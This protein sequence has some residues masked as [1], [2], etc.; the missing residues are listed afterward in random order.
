MLL[1]C[2]ILATHLPIRAS[3]RSEGIP[4]LSQKS[5]LLDCL[6]VMAA[7]K[8]LICRRMHFCYTPH[9]S[10]NVAYSLAIQHRLRRI[11][12][13]CISIFASCTNLHILIRAQA[14]VCCVNTCDF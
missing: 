1:C 13:L 4:V 14:L 9:S 8:P 5:L 3:A 10:V 6:I 12:I 2:Q 11:E 7:G